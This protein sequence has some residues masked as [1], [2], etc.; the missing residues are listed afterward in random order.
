M[1]FAQ[2]NFLLNG[3]SPSGISTPPPS[4]SAD[5]TRSTS[6]SSRQLTKYETAGVKAKCWPP[7]IVMNS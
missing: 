5:H 3:Y 6:D 4:E 2:P 7:L 1:S